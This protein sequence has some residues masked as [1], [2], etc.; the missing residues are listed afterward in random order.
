VAPG[1]V[2]YPQRGADQLFG[3]LEKDGAARLTLAP[4]DHHA[5]AAMLADASG[6]PPGQA[7]ADLAGGAAGNPSLVAELIGGLRSAR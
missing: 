1:P 4:L 7:L 5:V 6:A 2:R 3:L